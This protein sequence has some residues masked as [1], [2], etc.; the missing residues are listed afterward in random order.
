[1]QIDLDKIKGEEKDV[2]TNATDNPDNVP[3][4]AAVNENKVLQQTSQAAQESAEQKPPHL[5]INKN[6]TIIAAIIVAILIISILAFS[7]TC[8]SK[9]PTNTNI[10]GTSVST[11]ESAAKDRHAIDIQSMEATAFD[12]DIVHVKFIIKLYNNET[13]VWSGT[14]TM[15]AVAEDGSLLKEI[16]ILIPD[17]PA[18]KYRDATAEFDMPRIDF[19]RLSKIVEIDGA[20]YNLQEYD[21]SAYVSNG[22]E[23]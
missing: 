20:Q 16:E 8:T 2:T 7:N 6:V 18:R 10:L 5:K 13:S 19:E 1:M 22:I 4:N 11:A 3:E 21:C 14:E 12:Y 23:S 9:G 17:V 15:K